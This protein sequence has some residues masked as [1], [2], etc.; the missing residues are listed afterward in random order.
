MV[1]RCFPPDVPGAQ[2]QAA[3]AIFAR[4]TDLFNFDVVLYNM[5]PPERELLLHR[6]GHL[7]VWN[8]M[9]PNME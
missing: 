5:V 6:L 1:V 7:A 9:K 3:V 8:P 2:C 4:I